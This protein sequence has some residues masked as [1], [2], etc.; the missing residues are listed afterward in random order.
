MKFHPYAWSPRSLSG[1]QLWDGYKLVLSEETCPSAQKKPK[2]FADLRAITKEHSN[3]AM[4][5]AILLGGG[6]IV[7]IKKAAMSLT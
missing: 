7:D 5:A 1:G 3:A 4:N 2:S 6:V